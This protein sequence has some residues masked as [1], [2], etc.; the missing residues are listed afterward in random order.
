MGSLGTGREDGV[1]LAVISRSLQL[2]IESLRVGSSPG[3]KECCHHPHPAS[4]SPRYTA[5]L[6]FFHMTASAGFPR[7]SKGRHRIE[8]DR[9]RVRE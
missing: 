4:N 7:V 3:G 1:A 6:F 5:F 8:S 2:T 9:W